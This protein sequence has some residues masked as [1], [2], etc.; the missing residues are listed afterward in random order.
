MTID[1]LA[2]PNIVVKPLRPIWY[3]TAQLSVPLRDREIDAVHLSS[4]VAFV[5]RLQIQLYDVFNKQSRRG[6]SIQQDQLEL[7]LQ[8]EDNIS[9]LG[10]DGHAC[11]LRFICELQVNRFASSSMLGELFT[12]L[13]TPKQG[14]NYT[15]LKEYIEAEMVGQEEG[16][17]PMGSRCVERYSACP[18]S[19][20]AAFRSLQGEF[21]FSTPSDK[22]PKANVDGQ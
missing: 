5:F 3:L 19:V 22:P 20:F 11:V 4:A 10:V 18:M 13:F 14:D 8:I 1:I 2:N 16:L 7:F 9:T 12:L 17:L 21:G 6:R 15:L